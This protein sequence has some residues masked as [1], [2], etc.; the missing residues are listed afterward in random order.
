[1]TELRQAVKQYLDAISAVN[2]VGTPE[3]SHYTALDNLFDAVGD[4][5]TPKVSAVVQPSEERYGQPD[6]GFYTAD[7]IEPGHGVVEVKGSEAELD[8]LTESEQVNKYWTQRRL[9]LCTN[10]REFALVGEDR[11]GARTVLE[12]YSLA[13]TDDEF[14]ELLNHRTAAARRH[15]VALGEYLGRVMSHQAAISDP[16]DLAQLLASYAQDALRRV[17]Q[18][19]DTETSLGP[20]REALEQALGVSYSDTRGQE[21]FRS[22]LV[23]TLFYGIFTAW[24]LAAR[25]D[26]SD[27]QAERFRWWDTSHRLRAPVLRM[28]FHH[29][30]DPGRLERLNLVDVL[31]WTEAA[32]ERVDRESFLTRFSEGEAVQYFYEP[33]L[34]AFDPDLR[35]KLG[36]WYTP[37][38]VVRYMVA[39][40]DRALRDDL[41]IA[42]GLAADNVYVLDPCCGTGAFLIEVLR[43]IAETERASGQGA[44]TPAAVRQAAMTRV[45]GFEIMLAPLVVAHLEVGMALEELGAGLAGDQRAGIFL[46][47]ALLGWE[48]ETTKP[49][50]FPEL[51]HERQQADA[52]KQEQPILVVLGNPPY[53]GFAGVAVDEERELSDAYREVSTPYLPKPQGQ[54]LNNLYVR[55]FRMAERRIAD[56]TGQGI[57]CFISDYSWLDGLSHP[58]MRFRYLNAFDAVRIDNLN[59]DSR[60]TGKRTP[61]G[62]PDPSVFSTPDDPV[63]IQVGT[64]IATLVRKDEHFGTGHVSYRDLWGQ[65]KLATLDADADRPPEHLYEPMLPIG[66]IGLPFAPIAISHHW[67]DWPSLIDLFP[68]QFP[69][70]TTSRD[71]FLVGHTK[72]VLEARIS[73]YFDPNQEHEEIA[74]RYPIVMKETGR[75]KAE[76]TRDILLKRGKPYPESIVRYSY[77]PFDERWLYWEGETKLLDEKRSE[78]KPHVFEDNLWFCS[79]QH[80]RRGAS[81]PQA[82]FTKHLSSYHLIER[83][84]LWFPLYLQQ[85]PLN[86]Q[87]DQMLVDVN[88]VDRVANLSERAQTYIE[89]VGASPEDLFHHVL[90]TLHDSAYREANAG[91]LRMGWP[92]IPLPDDP[93]DLAQSAARGHRL[94]RLL[95]TESDVTDLLTDHTHIAVPT[96]VDGNPMQPD[97]FNVTAGWGHFGANQAVMPGQG[98]IERRG[99]VVDV[100]LNDRAYWKDI[101]LEVW[102]YRLGGYQV[103]KKWPSYRES[104]VLGRALTFSEVAW[105]SEV[106]RRTVSLL[107]P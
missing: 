91:G 27:E 69:G 83:G 10:L 49:M 68:T 72:D 15:G 20:I 7:N 76:R 51:E 52:V 36:V 93:A 88:G 24:V 92:R 30:T 90:A 41:G 16:R 53:S 102:S 34:E 55:F 98:K 28:L 31:D 46:T 107:T 26:L 60:R 4:Q 6:F 54:G 45:F 103:L 79:S 81:E 64:A 13:N 100:Y 99:N 19:A 38:E 63:G 50:P 3:L 61:D 105:F 18:A 101:P 56:R 5:L 11:D 14:A 48:P 57:V 97:D 74:S 62:L 29:L 70:V 67:F 82:A 86:P 87:G 96:T 95:D 12:R 40:V 75:F 106:A 1:M 17:E 85:D 25:A 59:G 44:A 80:L 21:F 71:A 84:G 89:S 37:R 9:V 78:Y 104:K 2:R 42:K 94:A 47:N 33:F 58:G 8:E 66:P 77:R 43:R 32:L 35:Q 22:T 65:S 39:R 73:D 23:Q